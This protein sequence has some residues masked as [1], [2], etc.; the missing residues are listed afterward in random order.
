MNRCRLCDVGI[1][2]ENMTDDPTMCDICEN[3]MKHR[4][5]ESYLSNDYHFADWLCRA[6]RKEYYMFLEE[7]N[8]YKSK[9]SR[10]E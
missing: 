3:K 10:S 4:I 9:K 8:E 6:H 2:E 5:S 7:F 1:S